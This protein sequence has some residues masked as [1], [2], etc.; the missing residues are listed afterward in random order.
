[1][2]GESHSV[3]GVERDTTK[4]AHLHPLHLVDPSPH[5]A[6]RGNP[7][8][9]DADDSQTGALCLLADSAA[10]KAAAAENDQLRRPATATATLVAEQRCCQL[11]QVRA[12]KR[13]NLFFNVTMAVTQVNRCHDLCP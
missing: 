10:H 8:P 9:A 4:H 7:T 3:R 11:Q 6:L 12:R 1:M 13:A 2:N 5:G